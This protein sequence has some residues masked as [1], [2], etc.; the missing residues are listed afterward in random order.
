MLRGKNL[1][2]LAF[3]I[4]RTP[5]IV[6]LAIDPDEHLV[7]V[8][9]PLG[10]ALMMLNALLPYLS[11]KDGTEPVPPEPH[12]FMA[13]IDATLEQNIFY[14]PKRQWIA[15]VHHN[16]EADHL[17]RAVEITEWIANCR[18]LRVR[19]KM[20]HYAERAC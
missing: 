12:S 17:G 15:D 1:K 4:N 18:R 10:K 6:R 3:V 13:N 7:E 20:A 9:S 19:F 5:Q 16:H 8:P 11:G 2:Y 14:L